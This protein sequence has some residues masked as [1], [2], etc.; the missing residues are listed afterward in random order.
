MN[1]ANYLFEFL[2]FLIKKVE[3]F[4]KVNQFNNRNNN[5]D[6]KEISVGIIENEKFVFVM[7]KYFDHF[8]MN[9]IY[10]RDVKSLVKI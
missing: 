1:I 8:V 9:Q 2:W 10:K 7:S 6:L 4:C 3:F 5:T